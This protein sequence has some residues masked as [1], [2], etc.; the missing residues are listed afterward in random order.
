MFEIKIV[1]YQFLHKKCSIQ[2]FRRSEG[3]PVEL[4]TCINGLLILIRDS[5]LLYE[6]EYFIGDEL[7]LTSYRSFLIMKLSFY[8]LQRYHA[9]IKR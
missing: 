9:R 6:R 8:S 5:T 7:T 1:S 4:R 3:T 2:N